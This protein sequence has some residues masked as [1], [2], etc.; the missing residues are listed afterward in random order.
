MYVDIYQTLL[1]NFSSTLKEASYD[2]INKEYMTENEAKVVNLDI[3]AKNISENITPRS[4]DALFFYE[5]KQKWYLIEFK[6]GILFYE[7]MKCKGCI[8][9]EKCP[10]CK[11]MEKKYEIKEKI[12]ESLLLLTKEL[13]E[14]IDFFQ[15]NM[16][17]ILVYNKSKNSRIN[18]LNS[19]NILKDF[20]PK[21]LEGIYL[22]EIRYLE[23]NDFH[24]DFVEKYCV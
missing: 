8:K 14:T 1:K 4:C 5:A 7:C 24:K 2:S 18:I 19:L 17:F 3:Y 9:C 22:K 23:K 6:N 15:K 16:T 11:T 12:F 13:N 21:R 20:V 10:K